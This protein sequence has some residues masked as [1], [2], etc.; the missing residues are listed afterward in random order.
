MLKYFKNINKKN[1]F[2]LYLFFLTIL[3]F[4]FC[5][6]YTLPEYR[7]VLIDKDNNYILENI[8]FG[9]GKIIQS[10]YD[11]RGSE[12]YWFENIKLESAR[13]LFVPYYL[14]FINDFITSNFYLIHLIKNI[15]FGSLLFLSIIFIRKNLNYL[16]IIISLFLIFYIPHNSLTILATE[17]E[18][19]ILVYLILMLFF[20]SISELKYKSVV[21]LTILP[22]I[23]FLKGSMFFLVVIFTIFYFFYEKKDKF[24][25]LV[26]LFVLLANI[27]WAINS[28][29]KNGFFAIG[30]KGSSMNA[31]NLATVTH[32]LF[33]ETYPQIRPDIHLESVEIYLKKENIRSEK[34]MVDS[35]LK[36]SKDYILSHPKDYLLGVLKKIYVLNLSP[37]KDAQMPSGIS[38]LEYLS[39]IKNNQKN[40]NPAVENPIRLS[41]FPNK[42]IFNL[43]LFFL[44]FSFYKYKKNS[45]F[46]NKVNIYYLV[47]ISTY[48]APYLFAWI[49]PRH[50]IAVYILAHFYCVFYL[51]ENNIKIRKILKL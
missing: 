15:F 24:R 27:I 39:N 23:F 41:N 28:F 38:N 1:I 25:Y 37:F 42:I 49:Y 6:I 33:N 12:I 48:L 18:E 46:Q 32:D 47:I 5:Y 2:F 45:L 16:F 31:I 34:E 22:L 11:G 9:F 21:M 51:I 44:I 35:L 30:P 26:V 36:K 14:M 10:I 29:N 20:T 50:A 19:G 7:E 43:S 13:R 3:N 17:H 4:V 40:L 8:A